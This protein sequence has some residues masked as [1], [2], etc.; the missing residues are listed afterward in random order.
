MV[1]LLPVVGLLG[2]IVMVFS[3]TMLVPL[4]VSLA[5]DDAATSAYPPAIAITFVTGL[6]MWLAGRRQRR[7][8]QRR[9]GVLLVSFAWTGLPLFASL[10]L[11][12]YFANTATPMSLTDAYFEAMS[13][14]T[15]TGATVLTGLDSLPGSINLWRCFLQ[16]MGGMGILV[17]AVAI[18]PLLGVGGSQLLRAEASG[19]MKD[20]K[21]T[22]RI[23]ETAK[24]LWTVYGAI[25]LLCAFLYWLGGMTPLDAW[26]HM[27]A[28][29]SLGGLSSHDAS[30]A[31]FQS[32]L[33]EWICIP[34]MLM[35]SCNF[36]LYFVAM[37]KLSIQPLWRDPELRGTLSLL[38]GASLF[39]AGLLLVKGTYAEPL[40][41]LRRATF[42]LVSIA[43]TTGFSTT[44]YTKWPVFAPILMLLLSGIATSA[45]STGAGIKMVRVIIL[46][47]HARREMARIVHP[48][49]V[50]PL[51]LGETPVSPAILFSILGFMLVYGA[52]IMFGTMLLLLSDMPFDTAFSAIVASV[53]NM[54]PGL[55]EVGPAG[56][57][58]GL[59]DFQTWVCSVAMMLGRLE[60]LSFLVL[61]TPAFW[62][63]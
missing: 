25:S 5:I 20:T 18:L 55:N 38:I 13:G 26:M 8:L 12:L 49:A 42:N 31:Y 45:G 41:A 22:P 54:G 24:G 58:A 2:A 23:A 46:V 7:E 17:L 4:G 3:A 27:F 32:P 56:N 28:T 21:L 60:M 39:V 48:N 19:P 44:D 50:H 14:L 62:R 11:M 34:F 35:A 6:A 36:A 40:E 53:N 1:N 61:L 29:I 52:T 33:L 47:K 10:P 15:T 57:F 37:R 51:Q 9:D 59:S 63:K 30:F 16:W 43:S